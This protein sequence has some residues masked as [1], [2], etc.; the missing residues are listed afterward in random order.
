MYA[1]GDND[2]GQQGNGTTVVNRKPSL[3]HNLEGMRVN[4][5][6]CGSSHSVAWMTFDTQTPNMTEPVL[7]GALK[8]PLGALCLRNYTDY[9][10]I[11]KRLSDYHEIAKHNINIMQKNLFCSCHCNLLIY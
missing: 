11:Y 4:R 7:F 9:L 10:F 8:D 5:V 1:W 3:V 2:H 6:A